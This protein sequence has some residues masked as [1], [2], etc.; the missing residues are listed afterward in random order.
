MAVLHPRFKLEYFWRAKWQKGWIT[1]TE[2]LV[3]HIFKM[4]YTSCNAPSCMDEDGDS[5]GE[6]CHGG[7]QM[8]VRPILLHALTFLTLLI[9][10]PDH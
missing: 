9:N 8:K 4:E 3:I 1:D 6:H 7:Q 5:N 2:E 10:V